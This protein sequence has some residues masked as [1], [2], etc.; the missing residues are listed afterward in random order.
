MITASAPRFLRRRAAA[1]LRSGDPD[2][3][4]DSGAAAA[5]LAA[6]TVVAAL[7]AAGAAAL[8]L[9]RPAPTLPDAPIVMTAETGA[10]YVRIGELVHPVR[11]L[12]SARLITGSADPPRRIAAA[13]L[14]EAGRGP[15]LGIPG[16]PD[17]PGIPLPAAGLTWTVCDGAAS[18]VLIGE[19][20]TGPDTAVLAAGPSGRPQLIAAGHRYQVPVGDPGVTR[21][22]HL[23]GLRPRRVSAALLALIPERP[24]LTA[25]VIPGAGGP[26][27][28]ALG[29]A[30]VGDVLRTQ[31]AG[32]TEYYLVLAGGV[33]RIGA[34]AADLVRFTSGRPDPD[35]DAVDPAALAAVPTVGVLALR[36]LPDH[37]DA[38]AG[39][40]P[41]ELCA[42]WTPGELRVWTGSRPAGVRPVRLAGADGPGPGVDAVGVPPGRSVYAR[43]RAGRWLITDTGVRFGLDD[44]ATAALGLGDDPVPAP[45]G[46]I[47]ALPAGARLTRSAA[48]VARDG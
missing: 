9:L 45:P 31:R 35:I 30:A 48:L 4:E 43:D 8:S 19:G 42:A 20:R 47:A 12:S 13:A 27:P 7:L 40:G 11:N 41:G 18:T 36:E 10:L 28:A 25:P 26:G 39:A 21:A 33:Q 6:G 16:A 44:E 38:V 22:L 15:L 23:D 1:A 24:P 37:L 34:L 46:V 3:A 14:R 17:D 29:P 32:T 2:A 5:A